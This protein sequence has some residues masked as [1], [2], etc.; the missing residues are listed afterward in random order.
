MKPLLKEIRSLE[1]E[2]SLINYWPGEADNFGSWVRAMIGPEDQEGAESFDML[3]CTPKWLQNEL[4]NNGPLLG[5]G[6][7][8][9][10]EYNYDEI[11]NCIEKAISQCYADD[12]P[13]IAKK[14]S[15]ISFW[16]FDDYQPR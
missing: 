5:R 14:L 16:E 13:G 3:V 9:I 1:L 15:R 11:V 6:T 7:I 12:W 8:I 10:S 2:D 4:E